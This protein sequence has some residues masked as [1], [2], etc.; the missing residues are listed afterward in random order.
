M[1]FS[2]LAWF[3][4]LH[5]KLFLLTA[6]VTSTVT[7]VVALV[8]S[9]SSKEDARSYAK[10][11]AIDTARNV[12]TDIDVQ[13]HTS[14]D[15]LG[16]F[17]H[18]HD[19]NALL[20]KLAGEGRSIYQID[21]FRKLDPRRDGSDG[22]ALVASSLQD[23]SEV[24]M[25]PGLSSYL[26]STAPQ[27]EPIELN[28][29]NTG[30]KVY[31]AIENIRKGKPP[32]GL[33]RVYCDMERWETVWKRTLERTYATLPA[34][35]IGEFLILWVILGFAISDPLR[36]MTAAMK[37][38]EQGDTSAR[39]EVRRKDELGLIAEQFNLM[40]EQLHRAALEREDLIREI[41]GFNVTLQERVD[42]ALRE[43]HTKNEELEQLNERAALLRDELAQQERLA[44][45]GQLTAAFAHEVGTPLNLVNSHLQLLTT[46]G[47]LSTK[48]RERLDLIQTQLQRVGD[49]V[50]KLLGMT[51]RPQ[52]HQEPTPLHPLIESLHQLWIPNLTSHQVHF[53]LVAPES[54]TLFVDRKQME[55]IFINLVNNA[56][57]AMPDGGRIEL[58]VQPDLTAPPSQPRWRFELE[59]TG[60]GIPPEI[61]PRVF[62]PMFTTKPEGKGTGLGLPIVR[63]IVRHH[64]GEVRLESRA[65]VG[66]TAHFSLPGLPAETLEAGLGAVTK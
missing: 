49:I 9:H 31:L 40:A 36:I 32:I 66:T 25:G 46:Q 14:G 15:T 18:F 63:E 8:T 6:L 54:C 34:V 29:G 42:A 65:G 20:E 10:Q 51:R 22:M 21:V 50:R 61:L 64:G 52:L 2:P 13:L 55:Q 33:I 24:E 30:W 28:T 12:A 62:K 3:R 57:D 47:D 4:S 27:A 35:I 60:G 37:R 16:E 56:V 44:V 11:L 41:R 45:A 1:R 23:E 5:A 58:R 17:R 59:D 48:T 43:L 38:L 53:E 26:K 39:A 7:V 19:T